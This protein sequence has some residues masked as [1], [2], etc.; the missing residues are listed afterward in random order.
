MRKLER[1]LRQEFPF[2]EIELTGGG[3]FRLRLPN[4]RFVIVASTPGHR[5]FMRSV[6]SDIR[7]VSR[8][9]DSVSLR[10]LP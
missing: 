6:R 7:R 1:E 3:H 9:T 5:S 2:T 4:G 10:R 8:Q